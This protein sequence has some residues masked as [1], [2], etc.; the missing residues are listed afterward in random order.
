MM[1]AK[2]QH[3]PVGRR[4][5][6]EDTDVVEGAAEADWRARLARRRAPHLEHLI[7]VD[8]LHRLLVPLAAQRGRDQRERGLFLRR[9][10]IA[11]PEAVPLG[12][13]H[14]HRR[15]DRQVRPYRA[16]LFVEIDVGFGALGLVER[17]QK[18]L[19]GGHSPRGRICAGAVPLSGVEGRC[20][21]ETPMVAQHQQDRELDRW[22]VDLN[23]ADSSR[24]Y[25]RVRLP[26]RTER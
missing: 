2:L 19:C 26:A 21:V 4:R 18:R 16:G 9:R 3:P 25:S 1:S 23:I 8:D 15:A 17:R 20:R 14:L 5:L 22:S 13:A 11:K 7:G 10:H 24:P 6:A 12:R